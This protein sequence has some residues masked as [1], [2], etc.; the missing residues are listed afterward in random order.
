M[1][2]ALSSR[3]RI[4]FTRTSIG[5]ILNDKPPYTIFQNRHIEIYQ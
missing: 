4:L 3:G 5:A 2:T 1:K